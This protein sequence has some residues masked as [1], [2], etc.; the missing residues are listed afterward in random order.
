MKRI[1]SLDG[2]G[3]RGLFSLQILKRMETLLQERFPER[4]NMKLGDY[5]DL[6]AGTSVG[7][8]IGTLLSWGYTVE[9]IH[10]FCQTHLTNIFRSSWKNRWKYKFRTDELSRELQ[11]I[12]REENGQFA[13]L[14]SSRLRTL[15]IVVTRNASTG[16]PW[17]I[18][19]CP[20]AKFNHLDLP[21]CNLKIPLWQLLRASSAAPTYFPAQRVDLGSSSFAFIDGGISPYLNP[22]FIA[23][24]MATLPEYGIEF[25]KGVDQLVLYSVGCGRTR[26]PYGRKPVDRMNVLDHAKAIPLAIL[27]S[28]KVEQD[29]ICRVIGDCR[30]GECID[31]E[32]GDLIKPEERSTKQFSY[33]RFNK[34]FQE[35]EMKELLHYSRYGLALDNLEAV[36]FLI[37]HGKQYANTMIHPTMLK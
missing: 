27:D 3:V 30:F 1:L 6:I 15:L 13:M 14:G 4:P 5:F 22:S 23:Y 33:Y 28:I 29:V 25:A 10:D 21:D 18:S 11:N 36:P 12:F 17:P 16:S 34:I 19:N 20:S 31:S 26:E 37:K 9:N 32:I 2:G 7:A 24:L 35:T 8:I